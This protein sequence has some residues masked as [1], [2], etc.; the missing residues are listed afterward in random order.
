MFT[1]FDNSWQ[2]VKAS[3]A[4]LRSDRDLVFFPIISA[5]TMLIILLVF[6]IPFAAI[7]GLF[8]AMSGAREGTNG[9]EIIGAVVV[10]IFYVISYTINIFFSVALVGAAMIRLDGGDPTFNDGIKLARERLPVIV[11]YALISATVGLVLQYLREKAGFL[12]KILASLGGLAWNVTTFLVVPILAAKNVGPIDAIKESTAL[13]KK[14][15]G[16]QIVSGFGMGFVFGML[17]LV[18]IVVGIL[19]IVVL[20]SIAPVLG[21]I[22]GI[23]LVIGIVAIAVISS[24]LNGVFRAALYRY[25]ETGTAPSNFDIGMIKGA[26]TDKD[27]PKVS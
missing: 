17:S 3:W 4:V 26:F 16:E 1:R 19:L 14:T 15:W 24:A 2:L 7:T 9:G 20:G 10:F 18:V 22:A 6:F 8:S 21:F 12:G 11:Q 27:K 25:A 5:I 13:L 23:A